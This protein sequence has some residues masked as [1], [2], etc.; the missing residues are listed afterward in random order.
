MLEPTTD[1]RVEKLIQAIND[2]FPNAVVE[3]SARDLSSHVELWVYVTQ[4]SQYQQ[5]ENYCHE[6]EQD[7]TTQPPIWVFTKTWTGP[8]PG[9]ESEQE[10]KRRRDDFVRRHKLSLSR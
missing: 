10:I 7:Q 6:L 2:K 1:S 5:I 4:L 9:G 3:F 8:W